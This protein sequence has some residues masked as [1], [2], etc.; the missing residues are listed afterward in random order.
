MVRFVGVL[1]LC[2]VYALFSY[3]PNLHFLFHPGK[4]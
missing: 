3:L 4:S 2:R 1:F